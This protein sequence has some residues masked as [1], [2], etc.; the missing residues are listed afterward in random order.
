MQPAVEV[1]MFARC[2][3]QHTVYSVGSQKPADRVLPT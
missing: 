1:Y 2:R 3:K